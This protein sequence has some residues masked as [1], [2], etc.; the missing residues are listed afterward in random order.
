MDGM[1]VMDAQRTVHIADKA[2]VMTLS[3]SID[4]ALTPKFQHSNT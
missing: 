2:Y 1:G 3:N 4:M